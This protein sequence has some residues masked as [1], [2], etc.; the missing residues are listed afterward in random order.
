LQEM[1][2]RRWRIFTIWPSGRAARQSEQLMLDANDFQSLMTK[3]TDFRRRPGIQVSYSEVG[4]L[5]LS[6]CE[7]RDEPFF[8]RAGINVGGIMANGD[9]LACPS[10]DRGFIQGNILTDSFL[11]IWEHRFQA[12]RDRRWMKR[13]ACASC[14]EWRSCGGEA[15]HLRDP[16]TR[17]LSLCHFRQFELGRP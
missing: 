5:G 3:V 15:F 8:C 6:E 1:G 4:Y 2:V 12:F 9:I 14:P 17:E 10:I 11:D 7:V 16:E 13:G